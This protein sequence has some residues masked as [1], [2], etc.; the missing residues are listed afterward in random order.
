[1]TLGDQIELV[2]DGG[3]EHGKRIPL[4][5]FRT[6]LGRQSSNDIM[7]AEQPVSRR[8]AEIVKT[9]SGF[10]VRDLSSTNGTYVNDEKVTE[11]RPLKPGDRVRLGNSKVTLEF[12]EY[13]TGT[14]SFELPGDS[15]VEP[16]GA[17]TSVF[18]AVRPPETADVEP[19]KAP[20]T[21]AFDVA[22]QAAGEGELYEGTVRLNVQAEGA[23]GLVIGLTQRLRE[24]PEFRLLRLANNAAIGVDIWLSLREPVDLRQELGQMDGVADVVAGP[25]G[26]AGAPE[27]EPLLTVSL[28]AEVAA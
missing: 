21:I 5:N 13:S 23:M 11:D 28:R 4:E 27:D 7:I 20:G 17:S 9:A 14:V 3:P 1:M 2:V 19:P 8:H 24:K 22:G 25:R 12:Q 18:E 15:E 6:T 16:E 10:S 26:G